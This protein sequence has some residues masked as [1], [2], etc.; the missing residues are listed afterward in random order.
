MRMKSFARDTKG[1]AAIEFALLM[2]P[3]LLLTLGAIEVGRIMWTRE[4]LKQVATAGARC[5]GITQPECG[6]GAATDTTM[7]TDFVIA[8]AQ[9]RTLR[10]ATTNVTADAAATCGSVSGFSQVT[11]TYAY[12]PVTPLLI[13]AFGSSL[14]LTASS[15]YPNQT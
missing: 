14:N 9:R 7:A 3:F 12:R 1:A 13:P 5:M 2:M 6:T 15:C 10:L 11:L 4:V 8:E